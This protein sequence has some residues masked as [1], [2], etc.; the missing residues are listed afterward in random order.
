[1][2][3]V[4]ALM[5]L[6]VAKCQIVSAGSFLPS[7]S[8]ILQANASVGHP[9]DTRDTADTADTANT[10]N[11]A[12]ATDTADTADTDDTDDSDDTADT[13]GTAHDANAAGSADVQ[14]ATDTHSH[15]KG[16]QLMQFPCVT[17][18]RAGASI[19]QDSIQRDDWLLC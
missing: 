11:S 18:A 10:A 9:A 4:Q 3:V 15:E 1:M 8:G 5:M 12:D 17:P 14:N 6:A 2:S 16:V 19:N 13:A 7:G